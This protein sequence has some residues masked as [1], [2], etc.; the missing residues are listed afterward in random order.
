[1]TPKQRIARYEIALEFYKE[2][3]TGKKKRRLSTSFLGLCDL[4][5]YSQGDS[6]QYPRMF[7]ELMSVEPKNHGMFWWEMSRGGV[8][9]RIKKLNLM[10]KTAKN[11]DK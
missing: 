9:T 8:K 11:L 1:M 7:D 5:R 3:P 6:V 2:N 4:I 10:I